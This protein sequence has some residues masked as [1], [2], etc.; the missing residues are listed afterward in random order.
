MAM[1]GSAWSSYIAATWYLTKNKPMGITGYELL[2]F[3]VLACIII[4]IWVK[5]LKTISDHSLLN[6]LLLSF[7]PHSSVSTHNPAWNVGTH[8]H[9]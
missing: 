5:M 8:D 6:T 9:T 4:E 1:A 7:A 3:F 2:T